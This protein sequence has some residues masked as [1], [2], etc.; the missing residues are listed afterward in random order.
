MENEHKNVVFPE[1]I[2]NG[3]NFCYQSKPKKKQKLYKVMINILAE[4]KLFEVIKTTKHKRIYPPLCHPF[5]V[6]N[7]RWKYIS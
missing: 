3:Q 2:W 4:L 1:I 7:G 5:R 6:I